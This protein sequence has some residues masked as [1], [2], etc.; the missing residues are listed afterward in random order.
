M[1][2]ENFCK[3]VLKI[4]L[5]GRFQDYDTWLVFSL[6]IVNHYTLKISDKPTI[7]IHAIYLTLR[8]MAR[9]NLFKVDASFTYKNKNHLMI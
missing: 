1:I 2:V 5:F 6:R 8:V 7:S 9:L 4:S 3:S